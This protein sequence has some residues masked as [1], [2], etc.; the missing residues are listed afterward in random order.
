M[1]TNISLKEL[2]RKAFRAFHQDGL[3]DIYLALMLLA[4]SALSVFENVFAS[5]SMRYGAYFAM[6]MLSYGIYWAGK[7]FITTP[8]IGRVKFGPARKKKIMWTR[9]ILAISVLITFSLV[10]L[11]IL[12]KSNPSGLT[13]LIKSHWLPIL[14]GTKIIVVFGFMAYF[15]DFERLYAYGVLL[16]L[17]ISGSML[18]DNPITFTV[19]SVPML[20]IG[21]FSFVRFLRE[22][23]MPTVGALDGSQ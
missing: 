21:L 22:Y 15:L 10:V 18:L 3:F 9:I 1:S 5:K 14:F 12:A 8:R 20:V 13:D 17:G 2:E 7:K 11:T 4:I 6:I 23:P 19:T 16:A